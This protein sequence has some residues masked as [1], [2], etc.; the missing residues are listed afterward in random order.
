MS[1]PETLIVRRRWNAPE[2]V[3]ID[4]D[5]LWDL[6]F[7]D[8]PGGVCGAFPRAFLCAHV[9][10]DKVPAGALAHVCRSDPP[11]PHELL[12]YILPADN[13]KEIYERLRVRARG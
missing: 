11:S 10:C 5:A 13:P 12:V 8:D 2:S 7:R 9:W 3:R 1:E 4:V 6:H